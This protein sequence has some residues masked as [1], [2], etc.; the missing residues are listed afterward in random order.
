MTDPKADALR[1]SRT[2]ENLRE[3]VAADAQA[4]ARYSYFAKR[5]D[6][7]GHLDLE[8]LFAALARGKLTH[9]HSGLAFLRNAVD[10]QTRE[11]MRT[12]LEQLRSALTRC[13]Y[14]HDTLYPN[15][16]QTARDEGFDAVADW[17]QTLS[18]A[19]GRHLE[20]LERELKSLNQTYE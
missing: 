8:E 3:A 4:S 12:S 13:G 1:A 6:E 18:S 16:A 11:P 7:E 10:P 20:R 14:E 5:A 15:F 17:F 19:S 2:F 9:A